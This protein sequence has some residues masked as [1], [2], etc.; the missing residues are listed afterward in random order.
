MMVSVMS[1]F[2]FSNAHLHATSQ[3]H[4]ANA[5]LYVMSQRHDVTLALIALLRDSL[6]TNCR[7]LKT[8]FVKHIDVQQTPIKLSCSQSFHF[9]TNVPEI[10][11]M[12]KIKLLK[13]FMI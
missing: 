5:H 1:L 6:C 8:C 7:F 2:L 9:T 11:T 12:S 10:L 4:D 13:Y 3:H